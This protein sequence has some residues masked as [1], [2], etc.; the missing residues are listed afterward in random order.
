MKSG[1]C[2]TCPLRFRWFRTLLVSVAVIHLECGGRPYRNRHRHRP[3]AETSLPPSPDG[4][5]NV[6]QTGF[7]LLYSLGRRIMYSKTAAELLRDAGLLRIF[8]EDDWW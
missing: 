1:Y 5:V 3:L 6:S 7:E 8:S 4:K 2:I